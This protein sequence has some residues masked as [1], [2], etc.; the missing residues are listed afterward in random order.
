MFSERAQGKG[1]CGYSI[2]EDTEKKLERE[3][4]REKRG[5]RKDSMGSFGDEKMGERKR[6]LHFEQSGT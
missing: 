3:G 6:S 2:R 4:R 1:S 5:N